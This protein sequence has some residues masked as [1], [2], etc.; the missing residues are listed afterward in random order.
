MGRAF[1]D[2]DGD[3]LTYEATT[4]APAAASVAVSGSTVTVRAVAAGTATVTVTATDIG[5]SNTAATLAFSVSVG[6]APLTTFTDHPILPGVTPIKAVHFM[7]L[8]E[9]IDFLRDGADLAPFA[10]TD[11]SPDGGV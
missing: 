4:S 2:P 1:R 10:W 3:P 11:S 5:G 8:R 7:E 6:G 9:R